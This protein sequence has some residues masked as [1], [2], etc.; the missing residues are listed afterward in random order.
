[1]RLLL[2]SDAHLD[3]VTAGMRRIDDVDAAFSRVANVAREREVDA[4]VFLGDLADPD[5]GS[6]LVRV[7][8]SALQLAKSL[9][10]D[11]ITSI[12]LAGNHDVIQDGS[13]ATTLRPLRAV[14]SKVAERPA[15]IY[16]DEVKMILLPYPSRAAAYDPELYVRDNA[17]PVPG[18]AEKTIVLAH[19]TSLRGARQ[20][21]ESGDL[22]RGGDFPFPVDEC[23]RQ[24]AAFMGNGHF[25]HGQVTPDGVHVPGSLVRLRFDE[26]SNSPGILVV[27]V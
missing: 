14:A 13:G 9:E 20:G 1:M 23:K 12:W 5:C 26:E 4:A 15:T 10:N 17:A 21:S 25:H 11:D 6:I 22:A 16:F 8:D 3:A 19:A 18:F 27:D 2:Y 24:G 7:L